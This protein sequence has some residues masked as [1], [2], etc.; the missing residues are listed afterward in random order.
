MRDLIADDHGH[1]VLYLFDVDGTLLS[2]GGVGRAAL[3]HAFEECYGVAQAM[4][5]VA[6]AGRTDPRIIEELFAR[7]L[8]RAP[9]IH[10][11]ENLLVRYLAVLPALLRDAIAF[12]VL[13][14]VVE[15]LDF[16][17]GRS[18][19]TLAVATGNIE[20]G[21][22]A[23]LER[24]GLWHRFTGG[25]FGDDSAE[26]AGLVMAAI[27][28]ARAR[29]GQFSIDSI[30]V[31]GDTPHD[32]SAARACGVRVLAVATG[33]CARA[34]LAHAGPDAVFDTLAELPDWHMTHMLG[35]VV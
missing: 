34:E 11:V 10:E 19:V 22:R 31:V 25:G 26:R 27:E 13:P 17:A 7:A 30:V 16:L 29:F 35:G 2:C 24:A 6:L 3:D 4:D 14:A 1:R 5:G 8:G 23:K 20:S 33:S 21:A 18:E 28:R 9:S 15:T 32:V 12:R